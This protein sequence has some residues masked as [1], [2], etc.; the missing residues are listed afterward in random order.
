MFKTGLIATL[1]VS[2]LLLSGCGQRNDA[3]TPSTDVSSLL[4][5]ELSVQP[6]NKAYGWDDQLAD[7]ARV[8]PAFAGYYINSSN[9][10]VI[11]IA[12]YNKGKLLD[13][14]ERGRRV[15]QIRKAFLEL[16]ISDSAPKLVKDNAVIDY[17]KMKVKTVDTKNAYSD[18]QSWRIGLRQGL[19]ADDIN[20]LG[21]DRENNKLLITISDEKKRSKV[22][23][24]LSKYGVDPEA[25]GDIVVRPSVSQLT[26]RNVVRPPAG[27]IQIGWKNGSNNQFFVCSLGVNVTYNGTQGFLTASHCSTNQGVD[28]NTSYIQPYSSTP[29]TQYT[30]GQESKDTP[31]SSQSFCNANEDPNLQN[32]RCQLADVL[33][34][35]Y[36]IASNRGRV[37]NTDQNAST[38]TTYGSQTIVTDAQGNA[39]YKDVTAVIGRISASSVI[40]KVGGTSG[41]STATVTN[42]N[43]DLD[44]ADENGVRLVLVNAEYAQSNGSITTCGG[45]SGAP[46]FVSTASGVSLVGIHSSGGSNITAPDGYK[47]GSWSV[48]TPMDSVYKVFGGSPSAETNLLVKR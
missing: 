42:D 4:F 12:K 23:E 21:I 9:E 13:E 38:S 40:S 47:C 35:S 15:G 45:D 11:L 19:I 5:Q 1:S 30:V 6:T 43:Y 22:V 36:S 39:T 41:F 34:A 28:G 29:A 48:F 8:Y 44:S 25:V 14:S 46:W 7:L 24:L 27:G 37:V 3:V 32:I 20:G 2:V 17:A 16:L 26:V 10:I 18:L 31:F 33:F